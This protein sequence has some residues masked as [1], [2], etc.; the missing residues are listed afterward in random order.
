MHP[1]LNPYP[2][3]LLQRLSAAGING[4]WLQA[5]LRDLAPGGPTFPE[6]GADHERRL[7]NLRALVERARKCGIGV[8]LY[9]N[10][11]RAM[12]A[13]FFAN[14][15]DVAGVRESELTALCTS[16]PAVRRWMSNA[17][18]HVFREVPD[19]AGVYTITASEN[20]TNC[21]S[22][23]DW[24]PCQRCKDR[25]DADIITEVNAVIEEGV[26]RGNPQAHVLVSDWGWRG[27]GDAPDM[28]ARLPAS[29][30]LMSVSE[31]HLPIERGGIPSTVG[32]YSI[33]AVGPGPRSQQHWQAARNAGLKIGTEIQCNNSCELASIP[34]LP[35]LDLVAEHCG[36]LQSLRLDAMLVG[37]T[38]GGHPSPN[39]QL[40][41]RLSRIPASN[42]QQ[43]L[44]DLARERF[45]A[46]GRR[47][48][49]RP[50][51]FSAK[52]IANT[53]F[54]S[55]W[56]THRPCNGAQPTYCIPSRPA[57]ARPCGASPTTMWMVGAARI[58]RRCSRR[59]SRKSRMAGDRAS[60]S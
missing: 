22:H 45:G 33:S 20:L 54:T 4:I 24:Q 10:E 47:T 39:L 11:P 8:Y 21:A 3:G 44:D 17:L 7:A 6:F 38:M 29:T 53:H 16:H 23:G 28:I 15:A 25:S 60:P 34:Y 48:R 13:P 41:E 31:W 27:H 37:W 2:D 19:L 57:T 32:E 12:P 50:G 36:N 46:A 58:L 5:V 35:V 42:A 43:V 26:H 52:R 14:H 1:A 40:V 59:S 18:A 30:C 55:V 49:G 51:H 56:F 9:I